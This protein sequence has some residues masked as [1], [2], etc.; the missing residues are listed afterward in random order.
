VG[1]NQIKPALIIGFIPCACLPNWRLLDVRIYPAKRK[2]RN[3]KLLAQAATCAGLV[4]VGLW[5]TGCGGVVKPTSAGEP[6]LTV[7]TDGE[8]NRAMYSLADET[9]YLDIFS[10]SGIGSAAVELRSGDSP[11]NLVLRLHLKG[12]EELKV[13][14]DPLEL[15]LWA[16]NGEDPAFSQSIRQVDGEEQPLTP[17]SP[18][19]M[20]ARVVTE[21]EPPAIPLDEGYF[22]VRLPKELLNSSRKVIT[23]YWVD[24]FR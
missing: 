10:E 19:W 24:F 8:G 15:K 9:T 4:M 2:T 12:L 20:E 14:G 1:Y 11:D 21:Q 16:A 7:T 18:Y 13:I 17:G 5:L 6:Q 22:E 23:I 3:P